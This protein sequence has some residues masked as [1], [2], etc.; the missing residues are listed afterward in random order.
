M[1]S[2]GPG[3]LRELEVRFLLDSRHQVNELLSTAPLDL[4][5]DPGLVTL[6]LLSSRDEI[7][8]VHIFAVGVALREGTDS[9]GVLEAFTRGNVG[10]IR[11]YVPAGWSAEALEDFA[12]SAQFLQY[13]LTGDAL[14]AAAASTPKL[15]DCLKQDRSREQILRCLRGD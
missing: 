3:P 1:T 10:S 14:V 5:A 4:I 7:W 12:V 8:G 9:L 11:D 6:L 2:I 13:A 15:E